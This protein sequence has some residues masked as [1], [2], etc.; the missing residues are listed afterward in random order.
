MKLTEDRTTFPE[1]LPSGRSVGYIRNLYWESNETDCV[2]SCGPKPHHTK[3][4]YIL[5][6]TKVLGTTRRSRAETVQKQDRAQTHPRAPET[7]DTLFPQN[8]DLSSYVQRTPGLTVPHRSLSV[9]SKTPLT[10]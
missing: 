5:R 4:K 9:R 10:W 6:E 2:D 8:Q 1:T 3:R 7:N